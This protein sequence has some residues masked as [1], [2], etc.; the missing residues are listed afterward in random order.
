M[1]PTSFKGDLASSMA[2][3]FSQHSSNPL[4][5]GSSDVHNSRYL[6]HYAKA[7][8]LNAEFAASSDDPLYSYSAPE[9]RQYQQHLTQMLP[10]YPAQGTSARTSKH[11]ALVDLDEDMSD[12]LLLHSAQEEQRDKRSL[13]IDMTNV[14]QGKGEDEPCD[15]EDLVMDE[16]LRELEEYDAV[17]GCS[18]PL[19]DAMT[20]EE[21]TL[22]R[23]PPEDQV[24]IVKEIEEFLLSIPHIEGDYKVIDR[25]G[26]GTFSSVYK[27][28]DLRYEE[29]DNTPWHGHHLSSSSAHYQSVPRP[30][31]SKVFVA[32][33][34]IYVTSSP[35]RIRNEL[36]IMEECRGCRH[37]SQ[38]ITAFRHNDQVAIIMPYHRNDDFRVGLPSFLPVLL[39]LTKIGY[40]NTLRDFQW[41][42]LNRTSVACFGH[43]EI[44]I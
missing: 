7:A 35:E 8:A 1:I 32:I 3:L 41:K 43:C 20:D 28:I 31:G 42:A 44:S 21:H 34:R 33:K 39:D 29:W 22:A 27:A 37:V 9:V 6:K 25:L 14:G 11:L 18:T 2:L 40:R 5:V 17:E 12:D 13:K 24:E 36:V 26:T 4:E 23:K 30:E 16:E 38:L 19:S 10:G 15:D